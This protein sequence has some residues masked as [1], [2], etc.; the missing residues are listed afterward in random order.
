MTQINSGQDSDTDREDWKLQRVNRQI[1][2]E[3]T[4]PTDDVAREQ[5]MRQLKSEIVY[6]VDSD[7]EDK[8]IT[9]SKCSSNG[10]QR[11]MVLNIYLHL[12]LY[13]KSIFIFKVYIFVV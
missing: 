6:P 3:N 4:R 8:Y 10:K 5:K 7:Y 2:G 1:I 12:K 13:K 11:V 9:E